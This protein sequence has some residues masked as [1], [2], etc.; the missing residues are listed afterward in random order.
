[1][2]EAVIQF[3]ETKNGEKTCSC[4][5][6]FLHSKYNPK[7]E[8]QRFAQTI[9]A[10]FEPQCIFMLE[11]ALSYCAEFVRERFPKANL[12]AIRFTDEFFGTDKLWDKIFYADENLDDEIF[13][14]LGEEK[15]CSSIFVDWSASRN[16]FPEES[17]IAWKKIRNAVLK[18]RNVMTTRS[19]FSKRWL[20]NSAIF[21]SNVKNICA[22]DTESSSR[23]KTSFPIVIAASGTSLFS[24]IAKIK[25]NR[26]RFFLVAVSSAFM[27]LMEN[28]IAPDFVI[29][30]DGG[31]WAKSHLHFPLSKN[32]GIPIALSTESAA[33]KETERTKPII[34]LLYDDATSFQKKILERLNIKAAKARRNGTVSGTAL[35]LALDMTD[36]AIF[37]CGLDQAP[38]K[39]FQHTQP[40]ALEENSAKFDFRLNTKE[41][42]LTSSRF[43]SGQSLEIYRNWFK[44]NSK[45]FNTPKECVF[46]L[47]DDFK[48]DFDLGSIRDVNWSEFDEILE[49]LSGNEKPEEK[50]RIG[51]SENI[52]FGRDERK[53][54]ILEELEKA[55]SDEKFL[56]EVFP[57]DILILKRERNPEKKIALTEKLEE[58]KQ[59]L[60]SEIESII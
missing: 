36:G 46:R 33:P 57:M 50:I 34:P 18:S 17:E 25:E 10:D 9:E 19:Y 45:K 47:S 23:R 54:I 15:I 42:R 24:S 13:N 8:A 12:Y 3:S 4:N 43:N 29:S 48:F 22:L 40:N 52:E 59:N 49:K 51:K 30:T 7:A 55:L 28:G 2:A 32:A 6:K 14:F 35:E 38:A 60:I 31:Y 39:G 27:T 44:A 58:K 21:A 5:G 53:K 37:L 20:K 11:P 56:D 16:A 41:T 1:M 26:S